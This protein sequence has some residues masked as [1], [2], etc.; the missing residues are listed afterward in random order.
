MNFYNISFFR[1]AVGTLLF[2]LSP[3]I[4]LTIATNSN[5]QHEDA[6]HLIKECLSLFPDSIQFSIALLSPSGE[7]FLG[8]MKSNKQVVPLQ[9]N[10]SIFEIGSITKVFSAALLA[11][12]VADDIIELE[13]EVHQYLNF[14]MPGGE[15]INFLHLATH[16]SGLPRLPSN[17]GIAAIMNNKNPYA[18]YT[19]DKLEQYCSELLTLNSEPGEKYEYSNLGM[20]LL[21]HVLGLRANS[22]FEEA[23]D[24]R[25]FRRYDMNDSGFDRVLFGDRLIRGRDNAGNITANWDMAALKGAGAILSN[26]KDLTL[27]AK[28]HFTVK[29]EI[30]NL[31][32]RSWYTHNENLQIGLGWHIVNH[33]ER[34]NLLFHNGNTGGYKSC[35]IIDRNSK[36]AAIVLSNIS[37]G[38]PSSAKIDEL[39]LNLLDTVE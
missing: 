33:K 30:I 20:G 5:P 9:N 38:H 31:I 10:E 29:D 1:F 27:F 36:A 3:A 22:N 32:S 11:S 25:I 39:C 34:S 7:A 37:S 6:T 18:E 12:M 17:M 24:Y 26:A 21:A 8:F 13:D 16:T 19:Q 28:A 4:E 2:V 14:P 35:M 15:Q 23:M